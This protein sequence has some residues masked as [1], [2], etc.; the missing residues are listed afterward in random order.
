MLVTCHRENTYDKSKL[1]EESSE[2]FVKTG[3]KL[4][5]FIRNASAREFYNTL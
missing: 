3:L 2:L 4:R 1:R 5:D